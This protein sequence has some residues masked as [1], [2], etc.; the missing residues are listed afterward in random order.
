MGPVKLR[1]AGLK[2]GTSR[3]RRKAVKLE[4]TSERANSSLLAVYLF[5]KAD[6]VLSVPRAAGDPPSVIP[7][8]CSEITRATAAG[9]AF[10]AQ[11]RKDIMHK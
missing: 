7:S 8:L 11:P 6:L 4:D 3:S 1:I 5:V 9:C 2:D 10:F